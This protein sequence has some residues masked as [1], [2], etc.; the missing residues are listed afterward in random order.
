MSGCTT[1]KGASETPA[2]KMAAIDTGV[3][4]TLATL[5]SSVPGSK[6]LA[7]KSTGI[8][9][10]PKITLVLVFLLYRSTAKSEEMELAATGFQPDGPRI[11]LPTPAASTARRSR[12]TATSIASW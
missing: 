2:Q 9:V 6:E 7:A 12:A 10:F 4:A 5:Y 8:L 1:N 3:D 11:T